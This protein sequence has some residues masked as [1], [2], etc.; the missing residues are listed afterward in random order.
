[1]A[2][3]VTPPPNPNPNPNPNQQ[4]C[5]TLSTCVPAMAYIL[6][7]ETI[8]LF[9]KL[10]H[11]AG[12]FGY[13]SI[14]IG[15]L[16]SI[17]GAVMLLFTFFA[18][19]RIA[20]ISKKK[21]FLIGVIGAIPAAAVWPLLAWATNKF[22]YNNNEYDGAVN[23]A[24]GYKYRVYVMLL[25]VCCAVAKAIMACLSFTAVMIQINHSVADEY[26][27]AVN[28]LGQSLAALARSLG[29]AL[30]GLCFSYFMV[31][32]HLAFFNFA[33]FAAL[34]VVSAFLNHSLPDSIDKKL[35]VKGG[36]SSSSSK[37]GIEI[38]H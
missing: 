13:D 24:S 8:P 25:L 18:L 14:Q 21:M 20:R 30:G 32:R 34:L 1:M 33:L 11:A 17:S 29:P 4:P 10:E 35:V 7:D 23:A 38:M 27:G 28:G 2:S 22:M 26:L 12:G 31:L 37:I 3:L 36:S 15:T 19:P 6:L 5:P 9:L 16:L